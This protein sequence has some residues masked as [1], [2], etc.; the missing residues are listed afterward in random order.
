MTRGRPL[1]RRRR[2]PEAALCGNVSWSASNAPRLLT[3]MAPLR[4]IAIRA[5]RKEAD[6]AAPS[7]RL[8]Q[9]AATLHA[10]IPE[11]RGAGPQGTYCVR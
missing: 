4:R 8:H 10:R 9:A 7:R 11:S 6:G 3:W 5:A 2:R 1:G